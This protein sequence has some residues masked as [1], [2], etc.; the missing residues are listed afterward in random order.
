LS[1]EKAIIVGRK[2]L[3]LVGKKLLLAS[4]IK[5]KLK[6]IPKSIYGNTVESLIGAIYIDKGIEQAQHFILKHI[7]SS[8]FI[9]N[10]SGIDYKNRLLKA[11]QKLKTKTNYKVLNVEGPD[12]KQVFLVGV[13]IGDIKKADAKASSI[14][15]A[16]QKAA[17]K[18][19]NSVF[20]H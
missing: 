2:H 5:S 7:Y 11:T 6:I 14:K 20:L 10:L 19:Y 1:Q 16:E 12:H 8:E 15:E 9:V 4:D 18:A 13:F 17:E 3:N